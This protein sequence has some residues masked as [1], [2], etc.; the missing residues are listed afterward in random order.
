MAVGKGVV[1][2]GAVSACG[3]P[4][5]VKAERSSRTIVGVGLALLGAAQAVKVNKVSKIRIIQGFIFY[6]LFVNSSDV[7]DFSARASK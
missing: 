6:L 7:T 1:V 2:V 4:V 3:S 5:G